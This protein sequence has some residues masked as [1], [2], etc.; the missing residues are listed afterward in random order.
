M[1]SAWVGG[2]IEFDTTVF[3]YVY[4]SLVAPVTDLRYDFATRTAAVVKQQTVNGYDPT[5]FE[6]HRL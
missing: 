1:Y 3:R 5:E 2:N 6:A 4:T